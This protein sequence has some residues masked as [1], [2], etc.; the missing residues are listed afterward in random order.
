MKNIVLPKITSKTERKTLRFENT[1]IAFVCFE[2]LQ[3]S[4]STKIN[5]K[6]EKYYSLLLNKY[7]TWINTQFFKHTVQIYNSDNSPRKRFRFKPFLLEFSMNYE[8]INNRFLSIEINVRLT[9]NNQ[10]L[11]YKQLNHLWDLSNG[12][13]QI[14]KSK[15]KASADT[16]GRRE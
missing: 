12:L 10:S 5:Q 6:I 1:S 14:K 15:R 13:L 3:I 4:P 9:R 16:N 2:T 8:F 11:G 7:T